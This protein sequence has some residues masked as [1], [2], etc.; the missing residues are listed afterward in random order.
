M[1]TDD[2]INDDQIMYEL[3]LNE[4]FAKNYSLLIHKYLENNHDDFME[5]VSEEYE[6]NL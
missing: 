4:Y 1:T 3:A 5:F 6:D 2:K